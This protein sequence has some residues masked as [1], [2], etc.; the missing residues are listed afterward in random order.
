MSVE[1]K[2]ER[3]KKNETHNMNACCKVIIMSAS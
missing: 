2:K 3:E 1:G